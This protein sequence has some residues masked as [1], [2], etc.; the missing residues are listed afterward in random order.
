[1]SKMST[2]HPAQSA[3]VSVRRGMS[4]ED[5]VVETP[6]ATLPHYLSGS[7]TAQC[8]SLSANSAQSRGI[9]VQTASAV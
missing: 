1:M 7:P 8:G 6:G 5:L 4:V 9:H 3:N 2:A